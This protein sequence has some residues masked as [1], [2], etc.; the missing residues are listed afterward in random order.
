M[1]SSMP[2]GDAGDELFE[3]QLLGAD[4]VERREHA[5]QDVVT[6]AELAGALDGQQ[7]GDRLDDA[8]DAVVAARIRAEPAGIEPRSGCS[9]P[10]RIARARGCR[11]APA[12]ARGRRRPAR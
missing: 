6:A 7:A 8:D 10:S 5:V 4:A 12:T 11:R 3:V 2:V 1:I 9:R